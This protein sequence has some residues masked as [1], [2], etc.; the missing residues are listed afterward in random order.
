MQPASASPSAAVRPPS[1]SDEGARVGIPATERLD[2]HL[3]QAIVSVSRSTSVRRSESSSQR[4]VMRWT[5]AW[6]VFRSP[7]RPWRV[8]IS[9]EIP[10]RGELGPGYHAGV[11]LLLRM[12]S[13][14]HMP[15]SL[16]RK[17]LT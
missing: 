7:G 17:T 14:V 16:T 9:R 10:V 6:D 2:Q 1:A 12:R 15:S 11:S 3:T 13:I 5:S 8:V 4:P